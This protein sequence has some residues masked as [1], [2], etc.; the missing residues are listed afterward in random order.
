MQ[1]FFLFVGPLIHNKLPESLVV[2]DMN[3]MKAGL[4]TWLLQQAEDFLDIAS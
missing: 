1:I 4:I 3:S 2:L